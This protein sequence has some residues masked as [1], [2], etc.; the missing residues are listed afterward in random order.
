MFRAIK[1]LLIVVLVSAG[2]FAYWFVPKY[3]LI[4]KNPSYCVELSQH[5]Y[6][7]GN[8]AKLDS[9]FNLAQKSIDELKSKN[10][11]LSK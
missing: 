1:W 2:A 3:S 7:C 11:P 9:I 6:Y 5:I 8:D 10:L 4:N